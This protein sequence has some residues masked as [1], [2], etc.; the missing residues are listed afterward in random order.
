MLCTDGCHAFRVNGLYA[1][2]A[3]EE[4]DVESVSLDGPEPGWSREAA[5]AFSKL[6]Y[7]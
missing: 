4:E 5:D 2:R 7:P 1:R 6:R 3:E